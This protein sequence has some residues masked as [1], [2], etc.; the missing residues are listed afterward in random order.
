MH[1]WLIRLIRVGRGPLSSW[2]HLSPQIFSDFYLFYFLRYDKKS[3]I[4][5]LS[6]SNTKLVT[7]Q[8]SCWA[9]LSV[10]AIIMKVENCS[11]CQLVDLYHYDMKEI[12]PININMLKWVHVAIVHVEV[13]WVKKL[14]Q[15]LAIL[16]RLK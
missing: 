9:I 8:F 2:S 6:H 4:S 13:Q 1:E 14:S 10:T 5:S 12:I 3:K 11:P 16:Q 7:A 15:C